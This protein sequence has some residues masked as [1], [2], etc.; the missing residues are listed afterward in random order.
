MSGGHF[1]YDE[2]YIDGIVET[3]EHDLERM[4]EVW[5]EPGKEVPFLKPEEKDPVRFLIHI[6]KAGRELAHEY[7]Y[8]VSD[9][10]SQK[11]FL[12]AYQKAKFEC[13]RALRLYS[14]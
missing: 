1:D 7:D 4:V 2:G 6:L 11:D 9:D 3:L 12:D 5:D 13:V 10:T 8:Y 14:K